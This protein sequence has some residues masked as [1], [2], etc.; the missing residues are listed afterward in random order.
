[1]LAADRW[2]MPPGEFLELPYGER[3]HMI[4]FMNLETRKRQEAEREAERQRR[5]EA[6]ISANRRRVGR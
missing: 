4:A 1:M 6:A 5:R 2:N 3:I